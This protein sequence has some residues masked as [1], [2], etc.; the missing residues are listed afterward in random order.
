MAAVVSDPFLASLGASEA[1]A[2][3]TRHGAEGSPAV[4]FDA[5]WGSP[6]GLPSCWVGELHYSA[7]V[8]WG[9]GTGEG[10]LGLGNEPGL[11]GE[12]LSGPWQGGFG[13]KG[14]E[15]GRVTIPMY[16]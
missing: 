4:V 1:V 15:K 16:I 9:Q 3:A 11:A 12:G 10:N 5:G 8:D 6:A 2:L 7:F 14:S 13:L